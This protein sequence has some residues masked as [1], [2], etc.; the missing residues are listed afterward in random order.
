VTDLLFIRHGQALHNV[1]GRWEG[2]GSTPLTKEG[3]R[4]AEAVAR[5]LATWTPPATRLY[6]SP[7]PRAWQTAQPI[8]QRLSLEPHA[9]DDLR[10]INF[11]QVSGLTQEEFSSSLPHVYARWQD[12]GDLTFEFPG[13]EQRLAFFRRVGRVLDQIISQHPHERVIVVAHGGTLRAGLAHLFPETMGDWWAYALN[14]ASLTHVHASQG[15]HALE[16]LNGC[17][18]LSNSGDP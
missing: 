18:H 3:Q 6:T 16:L 7:L 14:N 15:G 10:E 1:E 12:R 8:A 9:E 11:G 4:Q 17:D 13:G 5:R 2:W